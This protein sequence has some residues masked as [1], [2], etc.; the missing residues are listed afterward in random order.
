M[1]VQKGTE[2]DFADKAARID[3]AEHATAEFWMRYITEAAFKRLCLHQ[4]SFLG[5]LKFYYVC[6]CYCAY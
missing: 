6:L 3:R 1:L 5:L 4:K 2:W